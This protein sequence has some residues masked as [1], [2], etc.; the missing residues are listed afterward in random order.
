MKFQ[1]FNPETDIPTGRK[2]TKLTCDYCDYEMVFDKRKRDKM[3]PKM[4]KHIRSHR[5]G[6]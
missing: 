5:N 1:K 3:K 4:L 6:N 2:F